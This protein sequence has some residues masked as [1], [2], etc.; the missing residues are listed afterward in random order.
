MSLSPRLPVTLPG[1]SALPLLLLGVTLA[2]CGDSGREDSTASASGGSNS[3]ITLTITATDGDDDDDNSNSNSNSGSDS[4]NSGTDSGDSTSGSAGMTS[5]DS[6]VDTIPKL[7]LAPT[8]DLEL[9]C[10]DGI[11]GGGN[12]IDE[13]FIWVPTTS[14]GTVTKIDTRTVVAVGRY[15]TGPSGG[16]ES[17]SRTAVSGDG[18]FVV[19]NNR[20]TGRSTAVAANLA[21]CIDANNDGV[22]TTSQNGNDTLAWGTD[23]CMVWTVV[24]NT[25]GGSYTG[26]PRGITWTLGDWNEATCSYDNAKVWLGF[27]A[28]NGDGHLVMLDGATG[29]QENIV[30][31]P[32]WNGQGYAPYGGALDPLGRP[33]FTGL[34]GELVRVNTNNNPVDAT[35]IAQPANIQTYGMTV[36]P[37]G[38][39]WMAGCSGPVSTYDIQSGQW[40]SVAGTSACHRGMA[41]DHDGHGWVASNGPCEL[42]EVDSATRTLVAKHQLAQCST[43]IGVSVDV[44]GYVWLVDQGGWAWKID[45]LNV[46]AAQ[47]IS[48]P[49]D[50]YV[51]S[52]MTGGQL[53]SVAPPLG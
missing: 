30:I 5:D 19:V 41:I 12:D 15:A 38:N 42:V 48:L 16:T 29:V 24:H 40:I 31:V 28:N 47:M 3:G 45:P 27:L 44:D 34:R 14:D 37:N 6:G 13:S 36:D 35:R 2:G 39:P 4:N 49:G 53:K 17:S 7:D 33:W 11:G 46:P 18:R 32:G 43:A 21:D 1:A 23:E 9:G 26:G 22:I 25:W 52:D 51:Y 8:P 20:G 10:G 50:H